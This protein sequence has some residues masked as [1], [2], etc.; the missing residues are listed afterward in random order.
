MAELETETRAVMA[1]LKA[2]KIADQKYAAK[3]LHKA[4][5]EYSA[6]E[7]ELD[8]AETVSKA[9]AK[10]GGAGDPSTGGRTMS[11]DFRAPSVV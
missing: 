1:D 4:A 10:Y 8:E 11:P 2:G 6:L 7:L 5:H 3:R 9:V